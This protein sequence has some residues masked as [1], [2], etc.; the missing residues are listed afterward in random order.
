MLCDCSGMAPLPLL[1][2]RPSGLCQLFQVLPPT[3]CLHLLGI[4]VPAACPVIKYQLLRARDRSI[5]TKTMGPPWVP[6]PIPPFPIAIQQQDHLLSSFL[7]PL[8]WVLLPSVPHCSHNTRGCTGRELLPT[9]HYS[10][11]WPRVPG[12]FHFGPWHSRPEVIELFPF[13]TA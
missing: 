6:A 8:T 3:S 7:Q 11:R 5:S 10:G 13:P 4:P 9:L 1:L 12:Q 2:H